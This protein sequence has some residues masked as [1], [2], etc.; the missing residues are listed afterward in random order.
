MPAEPEIEVAGENDEDV[1]DEGE[2]ATHHGAVEADE[3][4]DSETESGASPSDVGSDHEASGST[5]SSKKKKKKKKK[6]KAASSTE[7]TGGQEPGKRQH[8]E[9]VSKALS[10]IRSNSPGSMWIDLSS[11]LIDSDSMQK[12]REREGA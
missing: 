4:N 8:A 5:T 9:R 10:E 6:K 11:T 12:A 7:S 3:D 1:S 2:A